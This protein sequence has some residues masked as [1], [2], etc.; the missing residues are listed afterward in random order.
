MSILFGNRHDAARKLIPHLRKYCN[1]Q[2][3]VMAVPRGGVPIGYV[4]AK[5]FNLPLQLLMTK[6]IGHPI[7][8]EVAIGSVGLE[9][10]FVDVTVGIPLRYINEQVQLIRKSL[11]DRYTHFMGDS[12]PVT[13]ENKI[14]IIT[15][16]GVA[17]GH[18]IL[19]S[20]RM[21]RQRHPKKIVVAVPVAPVETA[22]KM[23]LYVDDFICIHEAEDFR[24]V[25]EYYSDF[26]EVTDEE[27]ISLLREAN[28]FGAVA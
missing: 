6:K 7:N 21:M 16:D 23:R 9:D 25:G 19:G 8:P 28:K 26:S 24:G 3:A 11:K 13:I 20:I 10:Q 1:E 12:P 22:K 18:T 14:V 15:D 27:V 5:E 4:I 2:G 17:T